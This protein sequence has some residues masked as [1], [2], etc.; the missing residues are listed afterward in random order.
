MV[1][2]TIENVSAGETETISLE[3][4]EIGLDSIEIT[5]ANGL[6][7]INIIIEKLEEIPEDISTRP[8]QTV[9][10]YLNIETNADE[11]DITLFTINFKVE[12]TWLEETR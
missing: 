11:D 6:T 12:Q 9:Y 2:E 5:A 8:S 10:A 1:N 4:T 3:D 7:D